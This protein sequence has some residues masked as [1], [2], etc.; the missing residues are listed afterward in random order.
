MPFCFWGVAGPIA[1]ALGTGA[2]HGFL[3]LVKRAEWWL[4]ETDDEL[5]LATPDQ[6][7]AIRRWQRG[8]V[9]FFCLGV[10]FL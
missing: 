7:G 9:F 3:G 10:I 2:V 8:Q 1:V 4:G 6:P 5:S